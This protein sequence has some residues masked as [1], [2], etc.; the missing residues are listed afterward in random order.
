MDDPSEW[1][2]LMIELN[3]RYGVKILGGCCGTGKQ[4]L[5]YIVDHINSVE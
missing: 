2:N 4:H 1:G 3:K 5:Q